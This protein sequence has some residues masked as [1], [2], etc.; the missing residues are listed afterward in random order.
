MTQ[1]LGT[2][3]KRHREIAFDR[4]IYVVGSEQDYHF[5]VLFAILGRLGYPWAAHLHHL[6]YGMVSLPEGRLKSREGRVVDADD[7]MDEIV[8]A[9]Q[10]A[11]RERVADPD[12]GVHAEE[13]AD[14]RDE[15]RQVAEEVGLG[16]IRFFM[17][18]FNPRKDFV[19]DPEES[20]SLQG[21][22]GP[23]VQYSHARCVQVLDKARR[24]GLEPGLD[25]ADGLTHELERELMLKLLQFPGVV[26]RAADQLSP[27]M[28]CAYL[29]ELCRVFNSFY[30]PQA[31]L[32]I[33]RAPPPTA[34]ARLALVSAVRQTLHNGLNLLGMGA[35]DR[36]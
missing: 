36:M 31:E 10:K 34:R 26:E 19:F 3:I 1:D 29:I 35:P 30:A 23:Y 27:A 33:L 21:D 16:A 22:T 13:L 20:L 6:S 4:A 25:G 9:V 8:G 15:A 11:M 2:A 17:C 7:F 14:A 32:P 5:R 28:L 12:A 18:R 24:L